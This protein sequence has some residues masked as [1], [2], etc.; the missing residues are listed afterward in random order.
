[1]RTGQWLNLSYFGKAEYL[2]MLQ[3]IYHLNWPGNLTIFHIFQ[4]ISNNLK[5]VLF[6]VHNLMIE[7]LK[8]ITMGKILENIAKISNN[9]N[10]CICIFSF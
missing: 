1:V 9:L 6:K 4:N 5:S 7:W 8:R 2:K 10:T 3:N